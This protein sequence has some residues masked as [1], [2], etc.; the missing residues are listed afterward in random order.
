[1]CGAGSDIRGMSSLEAEPALRWLFRQEMA[2]S[3]TA[4]KQLPIATIAAIDGGCFG[5]GVALALAC[6]I[7]IA[8]KN[9][10]FGITPA[11]IGILYP[12]S[13]VSRFMALVRDRHAARPL[14][15]GLNLQ[16]ASARQLAHVTAF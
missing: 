2:R 10:V 6:D 7:R 12:A 14:I 13:E 3:L 15:S 5:A 16:G 8:G 9:A 11:Q 1:M 4:L